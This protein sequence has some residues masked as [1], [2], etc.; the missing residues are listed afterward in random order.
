MTVSGA[1]PKSTSY[2]THTPHAPEDLLFQHSGILFTFHPI[3]F[4]VIIKQGALLPLFFQKNV[5]QLHQ[6]SIFS[7]STT[8]IAVAIVYL[9]T[10]FAAFDKKLMKKIPL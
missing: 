4:F 2:G 1:K 9:T 10:D 3:I 7:I 5:I 8:V 6:I